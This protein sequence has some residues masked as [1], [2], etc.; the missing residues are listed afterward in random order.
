MGVERRL[1]DVL[2]RRT[3]FEVQKAVRA[4]RSKKLYELYGAVVVCH[5]FRTWTPSD[6]RG[7]KLTSSVNS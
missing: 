6:A 4:V 2:E 5:T 3:G 7:Q 1:G